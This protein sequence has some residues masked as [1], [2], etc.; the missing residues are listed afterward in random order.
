MLC[1]GTVKKDAL[2]DLENKQNNIYL[3]L[4]GTVSFRRWHLSDTL[5]VQECLGHYKVIYCLV[6]HFTC[7][8]CGCCCCYSDNSQATTIMIPK[9]LAIACA[10]ITH[11]MVEF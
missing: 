10:G 6:I 4:Q 9:D 8:C 5:L 3:R 7:C 2:R 11:V 1:T